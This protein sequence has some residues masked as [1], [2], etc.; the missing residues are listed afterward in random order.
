[1]PLGRDQR[2]AR[3][4]SALPVLG[5]GLGYRAAIHKE[6]IAAQSR[7]D[8]LEL[9]TENFMPLTAARRDLLT[10]L[11][12]R[13]SCVPHGT[14][15][16]IG[17]VG[18]VDGSYLEQVAEIASVASAPWFSDHLCFT[19]AG[20]FR[21][22]HLTPVQ[23]TREMASLIA[24]KA[25]QV[26]DT[27]GLPFLLENITYTFVLPGELSEAE[28]IEAVMEQ[29]GCYLLLDVTNVY[30]NARNLGFDAMEFL[31][32]IPLERVVQLHVAGGQWEDGVL[33]DSHDSPVPAEVWPL[34]GYVMDH[35]PV[36]GI[37]V[38]RDANFPADF[39]ELLRDVDRAANRV[40]SA[41][42]RMSSSTR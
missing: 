30:T 6:I 19:T 21:L 26:Q 37:L 9:I 39:A 12:T 40:R 24:A 8:W 27:V 34:V 42:D 36:R 11:A 38:E 35:A 10:D 31:T 4:G 41:S 14:E 29:S 7:I 33:L 17:T 16:S 23:W 18:P 20:G 2:A 3:P 1:V 15:L 25:R 32:M 28:F 13:F 22:T 5:A